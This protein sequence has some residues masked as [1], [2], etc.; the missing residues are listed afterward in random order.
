MTH[1]LLIK[2]LPQL[3]FFKHSPYE[4]LIR[5]PGDNF[6]QLIKTCVIDLK[7]ACTFSAGFNTD[8][9]AQFIT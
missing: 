8:L 1:A 3:N 2:S 9:C 7:C 5:D 6:I 4:F